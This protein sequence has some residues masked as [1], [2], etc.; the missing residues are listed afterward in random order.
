MVPMN[1]LIFLIPL[2]SLLSV[3]SFV[4][5]SAW[6]NGGFSDDPSN[7]KYG[8]HDW[9]AQHALDWLPIEEKQYILDNLAMYLYATELPDNGQVPDGI[10][11]TALH[12][13]YFNL[14]EVLI[15]DS[16]AVRVAATYNEALNFL[17]ERNY[18]EAAKY[19]GIMSHYIADMAVFGHVMGANTDWGAE[20]HHSDYE[21]YVSQ[22]TSSYD[23]EFNIYLSFDGSLD[24][25]SAYDATVKL[26]YDT[27][28]DV[29]GNLTCVWMD[30]N[31][32][33]SNPIFRN[34]CGESLNL[35]VNYITDVLH[36][37]YLE[38]FSTQA[39]EHIVINEFESNP[40]GNDKSLSVEEWVELYNPT[41][42]SVDISNWKLITTHG[43]TVTITIPQETVIEPYGYYVYSRGQEW[44]DNE[45]ESII[46][47]DAQGREVDRTPIKSDTAN[48]DQ[49]WAR[50]PNGQD[51]N[52]DTDWRFQQSTKGYSNGEEKSPSSITCI[53]FPSNITIGEEVVISGAINPTHTMA[54]VK[55]RYTINEGL[56]WSTIEIT[57]TNMEGE[58]SI[59]WKPPT[60][61][62]Y[63]IEASW[64]G[65]QDHY[66]A[67]TTYTITILK[68]QSTLTI[69]ASKTTVTTGETITITG[70]I[71]PPINQATINILKSTDGKIFNKLTEIK[72]DQTGTYT[73]QWTSQ[74]EGIFYLKASWKGDVNHIKATSKTIIL[75]VKKGKATSTIYSMGLPIIL[76]LISIT[77][78][79]IIWKQ[80]KTKT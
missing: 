36:T 3:S 51:N 59:T 19:V 27:T 23:S 64:E 77:I 73:Y 49:C 11:D 39:V 44:L 74:T 75:E 48:D 31:Y 37:L 17:R 22:R 78:I 8:T 46:L 13:I 60:P 16:A 35:A 33:W 28:F 18:V 69:E 80:M 34:R 79:L 9:I 52:S 41:S 1:R 72:T 12:H 47:L 53:V 70:K 6:S 14:H 29:D 4:Q 71:N 66:G 26:A 56:S 68:I 7:P 5:V 43:E 63:V 32:N 67:T 40:P 61:G 54:P 62:K 15:D 25:I 55:L 50:Y 65:D 21:E 58:Y 38:A 76:T 57:T 24:I 45:D 2:L 42:N 30:Q 20:H 10:G